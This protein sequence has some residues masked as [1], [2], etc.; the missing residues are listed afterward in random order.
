[1]ELEEKHIKNLKVVLNRNKLLELLPKNA[2]VAE[3]GVGEGVNY[4]NL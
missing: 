4:P 2:I 1:M 3:L